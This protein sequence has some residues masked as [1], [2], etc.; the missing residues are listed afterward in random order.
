MR[1]KSAIMT[2]I[3]VIVL[4]FFLMIANSSTT[5]PYVDRFI[6]QMQNRIT[7]EGEGVYKEKKY[8]L[9]MEDRVVI[10]RDNKA[11]RA[12]LIGIFVWPIGQDEGCVI[13]IKK[14]EIKF[15]EFAIFIDLDYSP[16]IYYCY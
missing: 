13:P 14:K 9:S 4:S 7:V 15:S 2:M 1:A 16:P 3:F 5:T 12:F 10:E 8:I 11:G 6:G